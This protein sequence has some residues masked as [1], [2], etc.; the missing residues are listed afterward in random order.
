MFQTSLIDLQRDFL[1]SNN[2]TRDQLDQRCD[3]QIVDFLS[4]IHQ[5][6]TDKVYDF[7]T[8]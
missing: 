4:G 2:F 7:L 5:V 6:L 3:I 8:K 1:A